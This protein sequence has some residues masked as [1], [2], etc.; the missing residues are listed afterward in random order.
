MDS[1]PLMPSNPTGPAA[2]MMQPGAEW[3]H[4]Q[5]AVD[6]LLKVDWASP[7]MKRRRSA[8]ASQKP[9]DSY[10]SAGSDALV[11]DWAPDPSNEIGFE[12]QPVR[13][14]SLPKVQPSHVPWC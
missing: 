1:F 6:N 7:E 10:M 9:S 14:G 4:S 3:D 2:A 8:P 5:T 11:P 13:G 12:Y